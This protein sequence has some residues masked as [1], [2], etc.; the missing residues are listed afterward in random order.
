MKPQTKP[1]G[2]VPELLY[3]LG[4]TG[5]FQTTQSGGWKVTEHGGIWTPHYCSLHHN[6]LH[7]LTVM[8]TAQQVFQIIW[9][10]FD[11]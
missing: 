3:L 11:T 6:K 5:I 1:Q 9:K 2:T 10:S 8:V 4:I 7:A